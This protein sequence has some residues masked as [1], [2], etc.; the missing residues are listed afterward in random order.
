MFLRNVLAILIKS[1]LMWRNPVSWIATLLLTIGSLVRSR[2][3]MA[4]WPE[5]GSASELDM[6]IAIVVGAL[7]FAFF[8]ALTLLA[9]ARLSLPEG[10]SQHPVNWSR[11]L[12]AFVASIIAVFVL[13]WLVNQALAKFDIAI[14]P[15]WNGLASMLCDVLIL[16]GWVLC[17]AHADGHRSAPSDKAIQLAPSFIASASIAAIGLLLQRTLPQAQAGADMLPLLPSF[18]FSAVVM[19]SMLLLALT[20]SRSLYPVERTSDAFA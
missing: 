18:L 5:I 14:K 3:T 4:F 20:T 16:S 11:F 17:F 8:L 12:Q 1:L 6:R 19:T 9:M 13:A 10:T 2:V 15:E 7:G